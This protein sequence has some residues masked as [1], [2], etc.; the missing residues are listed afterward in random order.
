MLICL[1]EW[2]KSKKYELNFI[3][4]FYQCFTTSYNILRVHYNMHKSEYNKNDINSNVIEITRQHGSNVLI[5]LSYDSTQ[6]I[7]A[8]K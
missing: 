7:S 6:Q 8:E 2:H 3:F 4:H 5:V 1:I